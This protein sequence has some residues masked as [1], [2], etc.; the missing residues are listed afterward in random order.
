[1]EGRV[2]LMAEVILLDRHVNFTSPILDGC[3]NGERP[4]VIF[5]LGLLG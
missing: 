5:G 2:D 4:A 1:M 3:K